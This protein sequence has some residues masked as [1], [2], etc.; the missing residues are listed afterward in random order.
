MNASKLLVL[1]MGSCVSAV[2][3]L[4]WLNPNGPS[5]LEPRP[6]SSAASGNDQAADLRAASVPDTSARSAVLP[7]A[8]DVARELPQESEGVG[9]HRQRAEWRY[10]PE[11]F[12]NTEVLTGVPLREFDPSLHTYDELVGA[13]RSMMLLESEYG[14]RLREQDETMR[15]RLVDTA[16]AQAAVQAG[17]VVVEYRGAGKG[18]YAICDAREALPLLRLR[19]LF[20][21][22]THTEAWR[23]ASRSQVLKQLDAQSVRFEE[24]P[25]GR[26]EIFADG[27][28]V[29]SGRHHVPGTVAYP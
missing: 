5:K 18:Q 7:S 15:Y 14:R 12:A 16:D 1:A 24:G 6:L 29:G 20:H 10:V 9:V 19:E 2:A 13:G 27:E 22:T 23:E 28:L 25:D 11:W 4:V 17:G 21:A 8:M 26:Y 3:L